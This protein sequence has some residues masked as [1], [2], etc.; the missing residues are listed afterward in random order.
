MEVTKVIAIEQGSLGFEVGESP[1]WRGEFT[2]EQVE[3]FNIKEGKEVIVHLL[4]M[5]D[6]FAS[7]EFSEQEK[8]TVPITK[9]SPNRELFSPELP[10]EMDDALDMDDT[11]RGSR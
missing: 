7:V 10:M 2:L 9:V 8:T 5:Q 6:T 11:L 1:G 3:K 4:E